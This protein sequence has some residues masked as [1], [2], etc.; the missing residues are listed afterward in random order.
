MTV[1]NQVLIIAW[2]YFF[3]GIIFLNYYYI[4]G[5]IFY[6]MVRLDYYQFVLRC[7][8]IVVLYIFNLIPILFS[9]LS[10]LVDMRLYSLVTIKL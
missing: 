10:R 9:G 3:E 5:I 2:N 8:Y 7:R 6:C 4:E 1:Q